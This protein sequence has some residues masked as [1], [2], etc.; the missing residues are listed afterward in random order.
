MGLGLL[1]VVVMLPTLSYPF[2][3]DQALY[4]Y[5]GTGW[6]DGRLPFRDAFDVKPPGI[7]AVYAA[8]SLLFGR[9]EISIR[10]LEVFGVLGCGWL[11]AR[12]VH[13]AVPR[14]LTG[15]CALVLACWYTTQFGFWDTAQA[16]LWQAGLIVA[17]A[18]ALI[19]I[20]RPA[21]AAGISGALL[22]LAALFKLTALLPGVVLFA[23]AGWRFAVGSRGLARVRRFLLGSL[24]FAVGAALPLAALVAGYA[25]V[26]AIGSLRE[27]LAYV[28]HYAAA[29]IPAEQVWFVG[30]FTFAARS[31]LLPVAFVILAAFGMVT[32]WR[33]PKRA[34]FLA[35]TLGLLLLVATLAG[36]IAQRRFY[37]YHTAVLG[38]LLVLAAAPGFALLLRRRL[39]FAAPLAVGF[40][41]GT[42]AA[43]VPWPGHPS[44]DYVTYVRSHW[45]PHAL[46]AR[47]A[48]SF[49][50]VFRGPFGYAYKEHRELAEMV[51]ARHPSPDD[52]LHIRGFS[53][54]VYALTGLYSPSR[55]MAETPLTAAHLRTFRPRWLWEHRTA[56]QNRPPRFFMT[57]NRATTDLVQL[58][59]KGY[60]PLGQRGIFVVFE[61]T[62]DP[63]PARSDETTPTSASVAR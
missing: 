26:G 44:I 45:A 56:L 27:W 22:A 17:A 48:A 4:Q 21:I 36:V 57:W 47:S 18:A 61:R 54:T 63:A 25:E 11:A 10:I 62:A 40:A 37:S 42:A 15:L 28:L 14:G 32:A 51:L 53:P 24:L 16:E 30:Y 8:A 39:I 49:M 2:G 1:A 12:S 52:G 38:P 35:P 31:P 20:P 43:A 41:L 59:K 9:A 7:Y 23:A 3:I 5:V 50:N 29:P 33:A 6:L 46:G 58:R 19:R 13:G 55:F 60:R 34:G